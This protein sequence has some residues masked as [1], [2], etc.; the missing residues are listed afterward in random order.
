MD[1]WRE[2]MENTQPTTP[3]MT[4]HS[5]AWPPLQRVACRS[6]RQLGAGS[7]DNMQVN[8]Q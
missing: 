5:G 8:P 1:L 4:P 3:I 7:R 6:V 2:S